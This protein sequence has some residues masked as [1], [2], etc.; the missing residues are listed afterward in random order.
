[1]RS[2][3]KLFLE[4][5]RSNTVEGGGASGRRAKAS[6]AGGGSIATFADEIL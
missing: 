2:N 1:M 5:M 3:L 4:R 6:A